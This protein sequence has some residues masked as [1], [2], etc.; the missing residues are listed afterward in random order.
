MTCNTKSWDKAFLRTFVEGSWNSFLVPEF[1]SWFSMLFPNEDGN[2][3]KLIWSHPFLRRF[4]SLGTSNVPR[5]SNWSDVTGIFQT[6]ISGV[7]QNCNVSW[8]LFR[9]FPTWNSC[10]AL[11]DLWQLFHQTCWWSIGLWCLAGPCKRVEVESLFQEV[12]QW[13]SC[14]WRCL[15]LVSTEAPVV[16]LPPCDFQIWGLLQHSWVALL[17]KLVLLAI[18]SHFRGFISFGAKVDDCQVV[19]KGSKAFKILSRNPQE[20]LTKLWLPSQAQSCDISI[21]ENSFLLLLTSSQNITLF[22]WGKGSQIQW[23]AQ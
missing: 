15:K 12:G 22:C 13:R 18:E 1:G 23:F 3:N 19:V 21:P 2:G 6:C 9:M 14:K 11:D 8:R 5:L 4:Y 10:H 17:Q 7:C 20:I 16:R